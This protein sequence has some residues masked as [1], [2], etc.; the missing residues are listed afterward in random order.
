MTLLYMPQAVLSQPNE[1]NRLGGQKSFYTIFELSSTNTKLSPVIDLARNSVF[2]IANRLN[3][4]TSSNTPNF[5]A[6]IH[7]LI[8]QLL[9]TI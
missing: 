4:P 1:T 8:T 2:C 6:D 3:S 9:Q 5:V 7:L